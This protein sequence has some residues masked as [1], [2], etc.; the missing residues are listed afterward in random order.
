MSRHPFEEFAVQYLD[1]TRSYYAPTTWAVL[2][3]R[4]RRINRDLLALQRGSDL[5]STSP[6]RMTFEDLRIYLTW[7]KSLGHSVKDYAHELN[8]LIDLFDFVGNPAVRQ[9][10][11]RYPMLRPTGT[12]PRHGTLSSEDRSRLIS[13]MR[14]AS[15][16][17]DLSLVR[18]YAMVAFLLGAGLRS[19]ELRLLDLADLDTDSWI[20]SVIHVKGED[21]YGHARSV[22]LAPE[23]HPVIA[24]YIELRSA[25]FPGEK[26]MF[27]PL[28]RNETGYLSSNSVL[29]II[30]ICERDCDLRVDTRI[31]RRSYGQD[32]LDRGIDSIESVSVLMGHSSTKTTERYYA[33]RKNSVAIEAARAAYAGPSDEERAGGFS[34]TDSNVCD[35]REPEK[36]S[37]QFGEEG[38][39]WTRPDSNRRPPPCEGDVITN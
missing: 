16:S 28:V 30:S 32:L 39:E 34:A 4:Y 17:S 19:K 12:D 8:A 22:L 21:S 9:C 25:E 14:R 13:G 35:G 23:F 5:S 11:I 24:R 1:A 2:A 18:S 15:E 27:P 36:D 31:F 3:R 6:K 29:R 7:R 38:D 33:R 26:A 10:L 20:L 37:Q